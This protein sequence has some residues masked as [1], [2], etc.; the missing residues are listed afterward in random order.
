MA[1]SPILQIP[2]VAPTQAQ[3]ETTIN[4]GIS[5]LERS[6]NDIKTL[7]MSTAS[8]EVNLTDYVRFMLLKVTGVTAPG[9]TLTVPASKRF[10]MVKNAGT[11][12]FTVIPKATGGTTADIPP[13]SAVILFNTATDIIKIADSA[14]ATAVNSFLGLTDAP[15]D[16]SGFAGKGVRVKTTEDGLEFGAVSISFEEL[17]DTPDALTGAG[18]KVVRVKAGEDGLEFYTLPAPGATN[19]LG[20]TDVPD[21]YTGKAGKLV[22][23]KGDETGVDFLDPPDPV[24]RTTIPAPV[25]NGDFEL[26]NTNGWTPTGSNWHVE[27]VYSGITPDEGTYMLVA[28]GVDT[29]RQI[30]EQIVDLTAVAT[31]VQLDDAASVV[32]TVPTRTLASVADT[33]TLQLDFLDAGD[34][35]V[36]ASAIAGPFNNNGSWAVRTLLANLP[37]GTRHVRIKLIADDVDGGGVTYAFGKVTLDVKVVTSQIQ[38]FSQLDD[39]LPYAGQAGKGVV[40][41]STEDGLAYVT[42]PSEKLTIKT[43]ATTSY[44]LLATDV[45]PTY[46]RF[47]NAAAIDVTVP[48]N[49]FLPGQQVHVRQVGTGK[50]TFVAGAGVTIMTPETL[51]TRK[52]GAT[53]H[54]VTVDGLDFD[55]T[56]DL[57]LVV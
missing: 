39:T 12:T 57:E 53:V 44:T 3:K 27:T 45:S 51:K 5:I 46:L 28:Y 20:L 50:V 11:S 48:P 2:Q 32:L 33:C 6:L 35:S 8:Q 38:N 24:V 31:N 10:F 14:A 49:T 17:N 52:D 37:I 26:G 25:F 41:N 4:D 36:G 30:E 42:L 21:V 18:L 40:V 22:T 7:D 15:H 54:L 56:G 9:K 23:V 55:L 29:A 19:L 43:V 16:F 1:N 47:T 34:V 13:G